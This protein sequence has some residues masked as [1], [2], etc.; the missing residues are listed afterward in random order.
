MRVSVIRGFSVLGSAVT[1]GMITPQSMTSS[2]LQTAL[3]NATT[4]TTSGANTQILRVDRTQQIQPAAGGFSARP[5]HSGGCPIMQQLSMDAEFLKEQGILDWEIEVVSGVCAANGVIRNLE[6]R[7]LQHLEQVVIESA[8]RKVFALKF[9]AR[10][11]PKDSRIAQ[12]LKQAELHHKEQES[13]LC[14]EP[15]VR[16][17]DRFSSDEL[18]RMV[19]VALNT[20]FG[21][22]RN[23]NELT[24][25][26]FAQ[27]AMSRH[28]EMLNQMTPRMVET[29]E[30]I[31][32]INNRMFS[33][34]VKEVQLEEGCEGEKAEECFDS[35][36]SQRGFMER[37]L[38]D[39]KE[40]EEIIADCFRSNHN[41]LRRLNFVSI[42]NFFTQSTSKNATMIVGAHAKTTLDTFSK[43][44][45]AEVSS[46]RDE[47]YSG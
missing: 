19:A 8:E 32:C 44:F 30:Q 24:F 10:D 4:L 29:A 16:F 47:F 42:R 23:L 25:N 7:G 37:Y 13:P 43:L 3:L 46:H 15:M 9:K 12:E 5:Q 36:D 45:P 18:H 22:L 39:D 20:E 6:W 21:Q 33:S 28:V 31:G 2:G 17:K 40:V 41:Q 34:T 14:S 26:S 1:A 27:S 35:W 38:V 11:N